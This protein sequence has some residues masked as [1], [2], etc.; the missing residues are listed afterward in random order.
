MKFILISRHKTKPDT[1]HNAGP[2]IFNNKADFGSMASINRSNP[3]YDH[4]IISTIKAS[5]E[6]GIRV[7]PC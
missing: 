1:W 6:Y 7:K 2:Y 3:D 5:E 4:K